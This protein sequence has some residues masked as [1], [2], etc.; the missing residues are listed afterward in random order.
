LK[1]VFFYN[2]ITQGLFVEPWVLDRPPL[3]LFV[4]LE[5]EVD[6]V[7]GRFDRVRAVEDVTSDLDTEVTS[8][9]SWK[10]LGRVSLTQHLTSGL[11]YVKTLPHLPKTK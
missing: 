3:D 11:D 4:F 10:G 9:C 8:D 2:I 5:P 6:L 7:L 1:K